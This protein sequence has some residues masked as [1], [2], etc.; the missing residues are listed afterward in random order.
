MKRKVLLLL[1]ISIV[2]ILI[3]FLGIYLLVFNSNLSLNHADWGS[4]GSYFAG[5]IGVCFSL[6]GII[7]IY[8]TFFEQRKQQFENTFQQYI[9]NYYSLLNLIKERWL[10]KT[11]DSNGNPIYQNGREI[12]GNAVG[13]I[14]IDNAENKFIE[15]FNIHNNV[16]QHYCTY[17]V[18]LFN[19]IDNNNELTNKTKTIY[20]DRFLSMLSTY[21]LIFFAYYIKYLDTN[22]NSR[23]IKMHLKMKLKNYKLTDEVPHKRQIKFIIKEFI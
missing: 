9:L 2:V 22:K 3:V 4:F 20:I 10:H 17:L 23:K 7:L 18:E 16:F 21:E 13:Y 5:T 8:L 14:N 6:F 12:F 19:I 15:I 11:S 1:I